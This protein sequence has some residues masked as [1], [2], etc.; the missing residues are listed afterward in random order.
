V[1]RRVLVI[2]DSNED[3]TALVRAFD[4]AGADIAISRSFDGDD[5]VEMLRGM[6]SGGRV[7]DLPQIILLDLNLPGT[8]GREI[9]RE[10][11]SDALLKLIPIVVLSTSTNP[12]DVADCYRNGVNGYCTKGGDRAQFEATIDAINRFW[13]RSALLPN[14][15]GRR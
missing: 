14:G 13:F 6:I 12:S 1:T 3:Y 15:S 5:A 10:M 7:I 9:L 4:G 8:D 11:K 2:E